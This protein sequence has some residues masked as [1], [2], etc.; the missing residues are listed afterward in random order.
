MKGVAYDLGKELALRLEVPF[1]PVV[2]PSIGALLDGAKSGAW[3]VAMFGVNPA[4]SKQF[5]FTQALLEIE[6]GYL[7]PSRSSLSKLTDVDRPGVRVGVQAKSAVEAILSRALKNA[8][9]VPG[10]GVQGGFEMLKSA[11]ADVFAANKSI[12]FEMSDQLPGSRVLAGNYA[13]ESLAIATPKA[14][15]VG[16]AYM[17]KFVENAKSEGLVKAAAE[18]AGLRGIVEA[19]PK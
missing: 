8:T 19:P 7:A 17:R 18:R 11:K 10:P 5:D 12:L 13:T 4:R 15:D 16:M 3:D 9:V 6:F 1:E 14:R 2:Y